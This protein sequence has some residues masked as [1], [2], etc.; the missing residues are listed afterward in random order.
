MRW[1][2]GGNRGSAD[3]AVDAVL[4]VVVLEQFPHSTASDPVER[5]PVAGS[6]HGEVN[7]GRCDPV[8]QDDG[9]EE[10][11]VREDGAQHRRHAVREA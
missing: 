2:I 8:R 6:P 11:F 10:G 4:G 1:A 3:G 5:H 9:R 7:V